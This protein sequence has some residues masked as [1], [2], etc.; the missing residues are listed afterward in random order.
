MKAHVAS[1]H[2]TLLTV[3]IRLAYLSVLI[4]I[5]NVTYSKLHLSK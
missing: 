1:S 3:H 2:L 4:H 5:Q